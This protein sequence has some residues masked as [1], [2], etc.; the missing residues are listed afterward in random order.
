MC[1]NFVPSVRQEIAAMQP[2][3]VQMPERD[4]PEETYPGYDAPILLRNA[5][6][7]WECRVARFGLVPRWCKDATQAQ[8]I[9]RKTYN[10]RSETAA[11][12]PRDEVQNYSAKYATEARKLQSMTA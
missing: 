10:A 1:T 7:V 3:P 9:G 8:T 4:W 2:G 6:G 11:E 5:Q 12:K